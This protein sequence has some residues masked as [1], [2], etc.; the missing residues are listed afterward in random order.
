MKLKINN[1]EYDG[2]M[3]WESYKKIQKGYTRLPSIEDESN[4]EQLNEYAEIGGDL[5]VEN[6]WICLNR[7][8]YGLKPYVFMWNLKR[9]ISLPDIKY[10][11]DVI[12]N[13]MKMDV[14]ESG[15]PQV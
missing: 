4:N 6:I 11:R 2:I 9:K 7:K 12:I 1:N 3:T 15:N 10:N 5:V 8:W 14:S 13:E